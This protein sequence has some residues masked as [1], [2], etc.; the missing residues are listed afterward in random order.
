MRL[1]QTVKLILYDESRLGVDSQNLRF[2]IREK[3]TPRGEMARGEGGDDIIHG[4]FL[5]HQKELTNQRRRISFYSVSGTHKS[6]KAW[7]FYYSMLI[8]NGH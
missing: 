6:L 5:L 4:T 1:W 8:L 2:A 7:I 3:R